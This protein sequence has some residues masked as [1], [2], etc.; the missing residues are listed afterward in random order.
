MLIA[1]LSPPT[2]NFEIVDS[3][4]PEP[5]PP[6]ALEFE[7]RA[8]SLLVAIEMS[9]DTDGALKAALQIARRDRSRLTLLASSERPR[10]PAPFPG[11][12]LPP[13]RP[14]SELVADA[15]RRLEHALSSVDDEIP[16][17]GIVARGEFVSALVRRAQCAEHDLIVLGTTGWANCLCRR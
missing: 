15:S 14:E 1:E 16:V 3:V 9:C 4:A 13:G 2:Y 6:A 17:I 8:G 12:V 7:R 10:V 5:A 11:M